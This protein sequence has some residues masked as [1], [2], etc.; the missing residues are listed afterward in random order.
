MPTLIVAKSELV[1]KNKQ[2]SV[3]LLRISPEHSGIMVAIPARIVVD[4]PEPA[5]L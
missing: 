4:Y 1:G 5:L 3:R 2:L